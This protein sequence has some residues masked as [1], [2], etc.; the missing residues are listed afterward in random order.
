M[1]IIMDYNIYDIAKNKKYREKIMNLK[2]GQE[3]SFYD[4]SLT[5]QYIDIE[6]N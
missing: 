6:R 1:N 2:Q 4:T 3:N 5:R